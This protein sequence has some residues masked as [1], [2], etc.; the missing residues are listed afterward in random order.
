[1]L[2]L[3][4]QSQQNPILS[5]PFSNV[6]YSQMSLGNGSP[7]ILIL[8][9]GLLLEDLIA[10]LLC[11][12]PDLQILITRIDKEEVMAQAIASE[13]PQTVILCKSVSFSLEKLNLLLEE[14][15]YSKA[16]QIFAVS[17]NANSLEVDSK[18]KLVVNNF[19]SFIDLIK[20]SCLDIQ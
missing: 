11:D 10:G 2:R 12:E 20:S 5:Y 18:K 6:L 9:S 3:I 17:I 7:R 19:R 16:V 1:M 4:T 8:Y 14:L 15:H 13:K